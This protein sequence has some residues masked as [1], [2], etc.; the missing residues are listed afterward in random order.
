MNQKRNCPRCFKNLPSDCFRKGDK[1]CVW[2]KWES[3][4]R[5][6]RARYRDKIKLARKRVKISEVDFVKWYKHQRDC[7]TYCGLTFK[8]LK[9]LRI[10]RGGGYCVSWDI[11]RIDSARPY[12]L[13]N[14]KLSC[15]VC[16]MAKGDILKFNEAKEIGSAVRKI[17]R[18]RLKSL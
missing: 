3:K 9:S 4:E 18:R 7:C 2:C 11:D 13:G 10:K 1:L 12:E 15:F 16:N 17:W 8:E 14:L 6:A 5:R